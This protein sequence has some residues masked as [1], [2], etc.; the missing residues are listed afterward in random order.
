MSDAEYT[1]GFWHDQAIEMN[2]A[3]AVANDGMPGITMD[4]QPVI[5]PAATARGLHA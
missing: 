5:V 4:G 2:N 3:A 1:A